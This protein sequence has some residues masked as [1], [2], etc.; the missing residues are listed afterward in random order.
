MNVKEE[1]ERRNSVYKCSEAE[2]LLVFSR[3]ISVA[4][5]RVSKKEKEGDEIN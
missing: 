1:R 5:N 3:K 4:G 2:K